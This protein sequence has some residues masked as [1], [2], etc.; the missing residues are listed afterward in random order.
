MKFQ[1]QN[2]SEVN[3]ITDPFLVTILLFVVVGPIR[4]WVCDPVLSETMDS[5]IGSTLT[6]LCVLL[7]RNNTYI[8]GLYHI[9]IVLCTPTIYSFTSITA[10]TYGSAFYDLSILLSHICDEQDCFFYLM[11]KIIKFMIQ[12][13][14]LDLRFFI[15]IFFSVR[16][17]FLPWLASFL[18]HHNHYS[19]RGIGCHFLAQHVLQAMLCLPLTG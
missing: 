13:A 17:L 18:W 2:S 3:G 6:F 4:Y 11:W 10:P 8:S 1:F 19:T 5:V 9:I 7:A 15:F 14:H 16:F 12:L